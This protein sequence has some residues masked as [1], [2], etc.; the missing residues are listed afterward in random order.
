MTGGQWVDNDK[1]LHTMQCHIYFVFRLLSLNYVFFL[2]FTPLLR[3]SP[4]PGD[5]DYYFNLDES[6]GVCDL[7]D[8]PPMKV[9]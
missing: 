4:P 1:T 3:L 6:E 7:F 9:V 8:V 2:V 5:Q